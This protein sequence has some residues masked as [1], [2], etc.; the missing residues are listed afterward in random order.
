M[1][2]IIVL[3]LAYYNTHLLFLIVDVRKKYRALAHMSRY[4]DGMNGLSC[5]DLQHIYRIY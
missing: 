2:S 1:Y 3:L 4:Y 5:L